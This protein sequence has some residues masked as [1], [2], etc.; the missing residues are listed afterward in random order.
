VG[1]LSVIQTERSGDGVKD[2]VR[3]SGEV[4]PFQL[5]VVLEADSGQAGELLAAQAGHP[6]YVAVAWVQAGLLG[7]GLC[8]VV[9]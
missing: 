9:R 2:A 3:C 1:A 5:C 6:S 8:A 4:A 7:R